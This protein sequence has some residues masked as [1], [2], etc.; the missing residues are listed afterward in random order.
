M[1]WVQQTIQCKARFF[2]H[3]CVPEGNPLVGLVYINGSRN[4]TPV[5]VPQFRHVPLYTPQSGY[6]VD[7][8]PNFGVIG[9]S[10]LNKLSWLM[11]LCT[12]TGVKISRLGLLL[13]FFFL[14]LVSLLRN[15]KRSP[16]LQDNQK[17]VAVKLFNNNT[18]NKQQTTTTGDG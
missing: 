1:S 14:L 17:E 10:P 13:L 3:M 9:P 8:Y 16:E 6:M 2:V 18:S 12:C 4:G 15:P 5:C 11:S 7:E